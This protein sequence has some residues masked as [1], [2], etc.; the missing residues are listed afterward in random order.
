MPETKT[1]AL[2]RA[3]KEG[4]LKSSVIQSDEIIEFKRK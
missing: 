4:F 2:D 3:K 1:E